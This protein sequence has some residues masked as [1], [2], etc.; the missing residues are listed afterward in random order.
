LEEGFSHA[1]AIE[2]ADMFVEQFDVG[3]TTLEE[4]EGIELS[5][6]IPDLTKK[7]NQKRNR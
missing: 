7:L 2:Y 6:I 1:D 4:D 5:D 3:I